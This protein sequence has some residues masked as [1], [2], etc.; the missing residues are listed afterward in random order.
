MQRWNNHL[1]QLP[2]HSDIFASP[3]SRSG[4]CSY[5]DNWCQ[6]YDADRAGQSLAMPSAEK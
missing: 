6:R 3:H 2:E 5:R 1:A 4:Y